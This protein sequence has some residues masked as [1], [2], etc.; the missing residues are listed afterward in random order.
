MKKNAK[1]KPKMPNPNAHI[2]LV[3]PIVIKSEAQKK[4]KLF[5]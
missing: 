3:K 1:K 4:G 5:E 2:K